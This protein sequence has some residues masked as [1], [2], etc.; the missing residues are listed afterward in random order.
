MAKQAASILGEK[1]KPQ[2]LKYN[3]YEEEE[4]RSLNL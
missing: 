1:W 4:M 2:W 3:V